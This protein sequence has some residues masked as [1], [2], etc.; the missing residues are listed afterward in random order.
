MGQ[1]PEHSHPT[2]ATPVEHAVK[3]AFAAVAGPW[4]LHSM[5]RARRVVDGEGLEW[6]RIR[7]RWVLQDAQAARFLGLE[8]RTLNQWIQR[9]PDLFPRDF[10]YLLEP[11]EWLRH[12]ADADYRP[13]S[14]FVRPP[15]VLT[16]A[17]LL[18][19]RLLRESGEQRA[20]VRWLATTLPLLEAVGPV[21]VSWLVP[22]P[23]PC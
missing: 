21:P 18:Q 7:G 22:P 10:T 6:R 16:A 19:A 9:R 2:T 23:P 15:R 14:D 11:E 1:L 5:G 8:T 17:G 20:L 12:F 4:R 13:R 3:H